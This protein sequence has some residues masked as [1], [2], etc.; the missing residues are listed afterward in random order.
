MTVLVRID[1]A[2]CR[3]QF[4]IAGDDEGVD[5]D[6]VQVLLG[7]RVHDS[8]KQ[9]AKGRASAASRPSAAATRRPTNG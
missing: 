2:V 4:A 1:L 6:K 7:E 5:L 3:E 9:R 8:A